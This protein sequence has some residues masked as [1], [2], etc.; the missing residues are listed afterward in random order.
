MVF[1]TLYM[2]LYFIQEEYICGLYSW[3][4]LGIILVCRDFV[5]LA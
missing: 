4:I 1:R 5:S 2:E 3:V